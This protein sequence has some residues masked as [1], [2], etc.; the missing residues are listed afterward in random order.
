MLLR[1]T[2]FKN[3]PSDAPRSTKKEIKSQLSTVHQSFTGK[4]S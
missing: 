4:E 1:A 2:T 3:E